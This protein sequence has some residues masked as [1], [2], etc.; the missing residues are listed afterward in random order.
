[1]RSVKKIKHVILAISLLLPQISFAKKSF[2]TAK[3]LG[4]EYPIPECLK[5]DV[6]K[7]RYPFKIEIYQKPKLLN[8]PDSFEFKT[9]D[10]LGYVL[11]KKN[12]SLS[13]DLK[14]NRQKNEIE[15]NLKLIQ[16]FSEVDFPSGEFSDP[17]ETF[18]ES[19]VKDKRVYP[20][21]VNKTR[22]EFPFAVWLVLSRL[23]H[24][25]IITVWDS[26]REDQFDKQKIKK[27]TCRQNREAKKKTSFWDW[28]F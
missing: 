8:I 14:T 16:K 24:P 19:S 15:E 21:K 9:K 17:R 10:Y 23:T 20:L 27:E 4:Y 6:K 11:V 5:E 22:P 7:I 18:F 28:L 13:W 12:H 2:Y 1:M 25:N 26:I 3:E